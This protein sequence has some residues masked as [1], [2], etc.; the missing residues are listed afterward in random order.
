M[1]TKRIAGISAAVVLAA[2]AVLVGAEQE[3]VTPRHVVAD[4]TWAV[5]PGIAVATPQDTTWSVPA[6][7]AVAG[8]AKA[9]PADTTW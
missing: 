9:R 3:H 6:G 5:P 7:I 2:L 1:L 4:T 8:V